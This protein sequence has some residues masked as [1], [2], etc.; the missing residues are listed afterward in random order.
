MSSHTQSTE[1]T[2]QL[3]CTDKAPT[4]RLI[5]ESCKTQAAKGMNEKLPRDEETFEFYSM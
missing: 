5:Q 3:T 4:A 2:G 1:Q